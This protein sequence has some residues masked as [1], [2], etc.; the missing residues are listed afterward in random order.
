MWFSCGKESSRKVYDRT[1]AARLGRKALLE[2]LLEQA[3]EMESLQEQVKRQEQELKEAKQ[4][5]QNREIQIN[6]AGSIAEAALQLNGIFE[7]AQIASQQYI[8]N[9]KSSTTAK[10]PVR[11]AGKRSSEKANALLEETAQK[12]K[13]QE[14]ACRRRCEEMEPRPNAGPLPIGR[15][16]QTSADHLQG[17]SKALKYSSKYKQRRNKE[18]EGKTEQARDASTRHQLEK[19]LHRRCAANSAGKWP[20]V[21]FPRCSPRWRLLSWFSPIAAGAARRGRFDDADAAKRGIVVSLR[22]GTIERGDLLAFYYQNEIL[23]KRVIG[24]RGRKSIWMRMATCILTATCCRSRILSSGRWGTAMWNS[25]SGCRKIS[26]LYWATIAARQ[27]IHEWRQLAVL[28][29]IEF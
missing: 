10:R 19:E 3:K 29:R 28:R 6:E 4:A 18:H 9:I 5:L 7:M 27:V 15:K 12:C 14:E 16:F 26:I 24:C 20:P 17:L 11:P 8:D 21:P 22:G 13:E 2:L 1:S 25:R 23:L